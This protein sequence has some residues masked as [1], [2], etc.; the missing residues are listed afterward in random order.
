MTVLDDTAGDLKRENAEL[1]RRLA[2]RDSDVA[3]LQRRLAERE[4]E[5]AEAQGRLAERDS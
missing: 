5:L 3:E 4:A 2:E 1:Q